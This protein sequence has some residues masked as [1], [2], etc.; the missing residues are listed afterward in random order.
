L[1]RT[2]LFRHPSWDGFLG[3]AIGGELPQV[4]PDD[5]SDIIFTSGT[6]GRP[7]GVMTTHRQTV[8]VPRT[9]ASL[10]GVR[11]GDR[12]LVVSP[13]FHTFGYKTGI[14]ADLIAGATTVP[15]AVVEVPAVL[16]K[17]QGEGITVFPATPTVF[18]SIFNHPDRGSTTS[19]ACGCRRSERPRCRSNWCGGCGTSCSRPWSPATG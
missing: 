13:F 14:V 4:E 11:E 17:V 18:Q 3:A 12:H 5:L 15:M 2:V 7:K 1:A 19:P 10:I 6:T 9:W 8:N 16:E